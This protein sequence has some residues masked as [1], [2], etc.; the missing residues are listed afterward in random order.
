MPA[1]SAQAVSQ[2]QVE[3]VQVFRRQQVLRLVDYQ[4]VPTL[5][6]LLAKLLGGEFG[7]S[8]GENPASSSSMSLK[9]GRRPAPANSSRYV[10]FVSGQPPVLPAPRAPVFRLPV[11]TTRR[12]PGSGPRATPP[13]TARCRRSSRPEPPPVSAREGAGS[14][15]PAAT[16]GAPAAFL[17]SSPIAFAIEPSP[18]PYP[19]TPPH[20]GWAPG[21]SRAALAQS[22]PLTEG[23]PVMTPTTTRPPPRTTRSWRATT[24][25]STTCRKTPTTSPSRPPSRR[26]HGRAH[27]RAR[28]RVRRQ[29]QPGGPRPRAAR[30][31]QPPAPRSV[32]HPAPRAGPAR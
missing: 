7:E 31:R 16:D 26:P 3:H 18:T 12:P 24:P 29:P 21:P 5:V 10:E 4:H 6:R 32:H 17:P 28:A 11:P 19:R 30:R 9:R 8:P 2:Q 23:E 13:A 20:G 27:G 1:S 25:T 15:G 22:P 14:H